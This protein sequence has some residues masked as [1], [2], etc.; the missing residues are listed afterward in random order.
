MIRAYLSTADSASIGSSNDELRA[1][2]DGSKAAVVAPYT[3]AE[4]DIGLSMQSPWCGV[5]ILLLLC[6]S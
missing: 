4:E 5:I 1:F 3:A 6:I 2:F